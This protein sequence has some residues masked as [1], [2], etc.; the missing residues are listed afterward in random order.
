MLTPT[1]ILPALIELLT[2]SISASIVYA[3]R[4]AC[5]PLC[6]PF[7][8][9]T[10]IRHPAIRRSLTRIDAGSWAFDDCC[11]RRERYTFVTENIV[12]VLWQE[13]AEASELASSLSGMIFFRDLT[14]P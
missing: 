10:F 14:D 13:R 5:W 7:V 11:G 9:N 6:S 8:F 2:R 12:D 3:G 4:Y 1:G